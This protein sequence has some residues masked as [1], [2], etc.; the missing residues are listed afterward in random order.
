[1]VGKAKGGL[2]LI[3]TNYNGVGHVPKFLK[4]LS[5]SIDFFQEVVIV[6][7]CSSD[8]SREQLMA[9]V[10]SYGFVEV[11]TL[12]TNSGRPAAPRNTGI[13]ALENVT[14]LVFLDIDDELPKRYL[15]FLS[16][17]A[18]LSSCDVYT[19]VKLPL[20]SGLY[21]YE[22]AADCRRYRVISKSQLAY[23]NH[24]VMSGSS[25]PLSVAR[26][27]YFKSEPLEDWLFW[28]DVTRDKSWQGKVIRLLDVPIGYDTQPSLSPVKITQVRRV[29]KRSSVVGMIYYALGVL[30]LTVEERVLLSRVRARRD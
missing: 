19:G 21:D 22:Y 4:W 7:D 12:S 10:D 17:P 23:K 5:K 13:G 11:I 20:R 6:D 14:R 30:R 1:M 8:G 18:I 27:K 26:R 9:A 16:Q 28:I 24:V 3:V 2:G 25:S 15:E 29:L